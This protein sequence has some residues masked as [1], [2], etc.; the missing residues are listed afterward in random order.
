MLE[1]LEMRK[2]KREEWDSI[3][4]GNFACYIYL[5]GLQDIT[6]EGT[7]SCQ[8]LFNERLFSFKFG[9]NPIKLLPD[10]SEP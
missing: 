4:Q 10:T 9:D 8:S 6:E 5:S 3:K 2:V 1:I 7:N